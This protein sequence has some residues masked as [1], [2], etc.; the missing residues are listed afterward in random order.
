M[1]YYKKALSINPDDTRTREY[2]GEAFITKGDMAAAREQ[3]DEIEKR[4][5]TTCED[6]TK[7]SAVITAFEG[8][9]P[10]GS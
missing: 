1:P 7:L 4:C 5:G 9:R 10:T 2:M 8:K 3:L 6:Y